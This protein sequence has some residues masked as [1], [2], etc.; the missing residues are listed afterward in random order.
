M[1]WL[2]SREERESKVEDRFLRI[3]ICYLGF[4]RRGRSSIFACSGAEFY[5]CKKENERM[6]HL[7]FA[8]I[9]PTEQ[10]VQGAL[11][12]RVPEK[13]CI[14]FAFVS[15]TLHK[16]PERDEVFIV[17]LRDKSTTTSGLKKGVT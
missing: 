8:F 9:S 12:V 5:V 3:S 6:M 16:S 7:N 15:S 11:C 10:K 4:P 2:R 14:C 1:R 17:A 13:K